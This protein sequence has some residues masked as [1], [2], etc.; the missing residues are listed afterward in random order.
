MATEDALLLAYQAEA[1][2][3]SDEHQLL[4]V[5]KSRRIG[6]SYG[7]AAGAVLWAGAG[8]APQNVYYV[9]YNLDMAREFISYVAEFATG[10]DRVQVALPEADLPLEMMD[11]RADGSFDP[12]TGNV[13]V[14]TDGGFLLSDA[15]TKGIKT[16]RVDFP[17]GKSVA[18]L[19]ST[20]RA[21]RGKQGI[22]IIDEAAFH[23]D[24]EGLIK[25]VLAA[26]MWGGRV[27]VISTHDGDDN[28]F[29]QLITDIRG[30]KRGGE[31]MRITLTEAIQQGLYR[32]ICLV[33]GKVW[34]RDAEIAWEADLRRIYGDAAEEELDVVPA[35]GRSS[36]LLRP[37]IEACQ[38]ADYPVLRRNCPRDFEL[39]DM[40]ARDA[41]FA[42]WF[43]D[44]IAPQIALFDPNRAT[45]IGQD[46]ARS[47]DLTA[48]GVGQYD[49]L[50]DLNC[51]FMI[52]LRN[53]PFTQQFGLMVQLLEEVP[54]FA[55][56]MLDARGNGQQIAEQLAELFGDAVTGV[57]A[58]PKSYMAM[59]PRLKQRL[60]DRT[61]RIPKSEAITEDLRCIRLV[62]G[63]PTIVD[64]TRLKEDGAKAQRHGDTAI[65]LM[66]LVAAAD[67][68]VVPIIP[69]SAGE[70]SSLDPAATA[71]GFGTSVEDYAL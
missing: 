54:Q 52:E 57:M 34:T 19:P 24:L 53:A 47:G 36:Y 70:R 12:D 55:A 28:F 32:R 41:W 6:L 39:L 45:F 29:N 31:V 43:A 25:A 17:S 33:Q 21:V 4:V 9:G 30:A 35:R 71:G 11:E 59:M 15:S 51:R 37:V 67:M 27:I 13:S 69:M 42:D 14:D 18:A 66:H 7:I 64:R 16:F 68:D 38:T 61:L 2:R 58:T 50:G 23:D 8:H 49:D 40:D 26:L 63:I 20:P 48:I 5:E 1:I 46:F 56:A 65:A 3:L 60:E 10:F 44:E 62:K 22:F